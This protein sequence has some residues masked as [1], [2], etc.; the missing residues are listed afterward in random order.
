M[1][2]SKTADEIFRD[3]VTDD[4][5][6]SGAHLPPKAD[7]RT[8]GGEVEDQIGEL[9][10]L[11]NGGSD[12]LG[13][14]R[15]PDESVDGNVAVWDGADGRKLKDGGRLGKLAFFDDLDRV[16]L[17]FAHAPTG[18][19][20]VGAGYIVVAGT[21]AFAGW[22]GSFARKV[23][24]TG[25][26]QEPPVEGMQV[27][28]RSRQAIYV[29]N[30]NGWV[31]ATR[32]F[33]TGDM[34]LYVGK[35]LPNPSISIAS[36]AVVSSAAHGRAAGDPVVFNVPRH[37][38]EATISIATPCV[39]TMD[40]D[41]AAGRPIKLD[42][43]GALPTG[44]T[45]GATVYVSATGLSASGFQI[46]AT[47][48]GAS[49]NTTGSQSGAHFVSTVGALP[50]GVEA[51]TTYYVR[52]DGL[53]PDAFEISESPGGDAIDTS[54]TV[55][56]APIYGGWT[57]SDTTGDGTEAKP[58]LTTAK[59]VSYLRQ[60]DC[61]GH[62]AVI[63][64][65]EGHHPETVY[66]SASLFPLNI[67]TLTFQGSDVSE[68]LLTGIDFII[69]DAG[70][71]VFITGGYETTGVQ[72]AD[73]AATQIVD[74]S[75]SYI[76][77]GPHLMA[78]GGSID[79]AGGKETCEGSPSGHLFSALDGKVKTY[80]PAAI[81]LINQPAWG[82]AFASAFHEGLIYAPFWSMIATVRGTAT[83]DSGSALGSASIETLGAPFP[84][85]GTMYASP[86]SYCN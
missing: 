26:R 35:A 63:K 30:G 67:G 73:G 59:A 25:W 77:D 33:L 29:A 20:P 65:C 18:T 27:W 9:Q 46:S 55:D 70:T 61:D 45:A 52:A 37:R 28:V 5:P 34:T 42:S 76:G 84:G 72:S 32:P 10:D 51:G 24:S 48:G 22:D 14:V 60:Y 31:P 23:S 21:G 16:A 62:D 7:V 75:M 80:L 86:D 64:H 17:S 6:L 39:V 83:G 38:K 19:E 47:P 50:D 66:L 78:N 82:T 85:N 79:V 15:G 54:G 40:N 69:A 53:T 74:A 43:T 8:W 36:P 58:F 57:G 41:F 56:G 12:V 3:Y 81:D 4:V 11:V 2:F 49:I 13:N 68:F 71:R 1:P 44:I